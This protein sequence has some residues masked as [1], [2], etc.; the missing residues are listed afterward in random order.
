MKK[1]VKS[2]A[3]NEKENIYSLKGFDKVFKFTLAQTFKNKAYRVS[4]IMFIVLMAAMGPIQY[5]SSRSQMAATESMTSVKIKDAVTENI[6]IVNQTNVAFSDKNIAKEDVG[7]G[8]TNIQVIDGA[9]DDSST[10][11]AGLGKKDLCAFITRDASAF[12]VDVIRSDDSEVSNEEIDNVGAILQ[13]SFNNARLEG[14]NMDQSDV[15]LIQK[16]VYTEGVM[17]QEE[18]VAAQSN[19]ITSS[20]M[21]SFFLVVAILIFI[22]STMSTSFIISSVTEEKTSKLV[23]S[24]LVSVRPMAL[25]M[26]KVC[27]MMAYIL[28]IL[29]GGFVGSKISNLVMKYGFNIDTS[30]GISAGQFDFNMIFQFGTI[31]VVLIVISVLITYFAFGG[32]SGMIG[33]ACTKTE[34]VQSA[35]GTVMT[36]VMLGYLGSTFIMGMD[37]PI[38][39]T[40]ASLVPPFSFYTS[41]VYYLTGRISLVLFLLSILIQLLTVAGICILC[42][43]TYRR[44]I[45]N[46]S[47]KPKLIEV[48]RAA[49]N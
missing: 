29:V 30:A 49:K 40:I 18:Y 25:L 45:L 11:I 42:A 4:L 24:I 16:G 2:N 47:S 13:E 20:K 38:V 14:A 17:T 33:A 12:K 6:T 22:V 32:F 9:E 46:D 34:D 44:L 31:G 48:L 1:A 26:G 19:A 8:H 10:V 7:L 21:M 23:E 35:S 28:S 15:Q 37:L 36:V 43:K 41:V 27:G 3:V 39:N 5:F